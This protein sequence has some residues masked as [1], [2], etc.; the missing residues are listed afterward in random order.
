MNRLLLCCAAA[1]LT[2]SIVACGSKSSAKSDSSSTAAAEKPGSDTPKP[3]S[4]GSAATASSAAAPVEPAKPFD[5]KGPGPA[6]LSLSEG[7]TFL[8]E[9]GK[10]TKISDYSSDSMEVGKDGRIY[11]SGIESV[12]VV[13][14]KATKLDAPGTDL[15]LGGDGTLWALIG[16]EHEIAKRGAD[17]QWTKE[18]IPNSEG[19]TL[20]KIAVDEK[21]DVY[22]AS[23]EKMF[24]KRG[25]TWTS[26]GFK[27]LYKGEETVFVSGLTLFGGEVYMV[28][29]SGVKTVEGKTIKLPAEYGILSISSGGSGTRAADGTLALYGSDEI[30]VVAPDGKITHKKLE[31]MQGIKGSS[32]DGFAVDGQGRRWLGVAGQLYILDKDDKVLQTWP[33]GS[34]PGAIRFVSVVGAGPELPPAPDPVVK[35]PVKGRLVVDGAPVKNTEIVACGSPHLFVT[36]KTPCSDQPVELAG[37]TDDEGK[38]RFESVPR[39]SY[40]FAW[41][42]GGSWKITLGGSGSCC[43]KL[44]DGQE[45]DMNDLQVKSN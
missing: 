30:Y 42:E 45:F 23:L 31:T 5:A 7:G 20:H 10:L 28:S 40:G 21:G 41:R 39:G 8:F 12:V 6:I 17:G 14:G 15:A 34:L 36:G 27:E 32:V 1:L 13:N 44:T 38:F 9:G 26:Q 2:T 43:A 24:T 16:Y 18:K 37:K 4:S 25:G 19:E 35:A 29:S 22:V 3:K 33:V 11:V